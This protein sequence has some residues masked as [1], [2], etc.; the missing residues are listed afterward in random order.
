MAHW[1]D[2][3]ATYSDACIAYGVD[4]PE[5]IAAELRADA[6]E[7]N[8]RCMDAMMAGVI[9]PNAYFA[10]PLDDYIPF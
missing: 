5:Q 4:T 8:E 6:E 10:E 7:Y 3:F 2:E 9:Q 1:S